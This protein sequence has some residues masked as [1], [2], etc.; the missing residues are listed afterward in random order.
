MQG[1]IGRKSIWLSRLVI[2]LCLASWAIPRALT[3]VSTGSIL[4][5]VTDPNGLSIGNAK[6]T[7]TNRSTNI[8]RVVETNADGLYT[9]PNLQP[10]HY[11][12]SVVAK[13]FQAQVESDIV[14]D[15][16]AARTVNFALKI[17]NTAE[18]VVVT[19]SGP[20]VDLAS[21]TVM[22][23][24]DDHTIVQLPLNGRDWAS[25]A[26]LQPGVSAVRTQSVV[27]ISNQRANRGVGN[28][29]TVSGAPAADEQL[30]R[31]RHQHQRL[32]ERRARR[33]DWK[34]PGS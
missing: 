33:R 4:G 16:G 19:A 34:Q 22:P 25:L 24:V 31:R 12:V 20:S 30:P 13:D 10:G 18:K 15:V 1:N 8:A 14:L 7:V 26:N 5:A 27:S 32:L 2:L 17:G 23:V 11:D 6:V 3:Q 21:S 9:A 29:L 28:Q